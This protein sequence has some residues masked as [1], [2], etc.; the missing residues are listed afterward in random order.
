MYRDSRGALQGLGNAATF[1]E[2]VAVAN[3]TVGQITDSFQLPFFSRKALSGEIGAG[4][5]RWGH[6]ISS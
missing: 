5:G 6:L 4:K 2:E 1:Q 3:P